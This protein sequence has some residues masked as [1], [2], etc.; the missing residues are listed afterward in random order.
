M[1]KFN[2]LGDVDSLNLPA[3]KIIKKVTKAIRKT[4]GIHKKHVVSFIVVDNNEIQRINREYRSIDRPTD[5]ISFA[6]VDGDE[7]GELPYELGDI[8]INHER[9]KSQALDYGHSET[10]EFAFLATHGMLHLLGF[11]HMDKPSEE[12]MFKLQYVI[13]ESINIKR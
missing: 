12:I 6:M 10:R 9:V 1:I 3:K 7:S 4:L 11:D 2:L 8:F 5:V 13:L